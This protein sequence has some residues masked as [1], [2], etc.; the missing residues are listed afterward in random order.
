MLSCLIVAKYVNFDVL[1]LWICDL[2]NLWWWIVYY[3]QSMQNLV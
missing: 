2:L 3:F 1:E